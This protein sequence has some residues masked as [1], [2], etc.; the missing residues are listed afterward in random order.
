MAKPSMAQSVKTLLNFIFNHRNYHEEK[1]ELKE[2][3]TIT[4][5]L[6]AKAVEQ[7]HKIAPTKEFLG[8]KPL[9]K[10]KQQK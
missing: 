4:F 1:K 2:G 8:E 7:K 9:G 6:K 5:G 3:E 10:K